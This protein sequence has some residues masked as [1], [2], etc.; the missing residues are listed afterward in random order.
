MKKVFSKYERM[1]DGVGEKGAPIAGSEAG[2]STFLGDPRG[3]GKDVVKKS[4]C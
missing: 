2:A 4:A 3:A 1:G